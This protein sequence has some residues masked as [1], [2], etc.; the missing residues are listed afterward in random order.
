MSEQRRPPRDSI[1]VGRAVFPLWSKLG[2]AFGLLMA[3][4]LASFGWSDFRHDLQR[5]TDRREV[6]LMGLAQSM[7][8]AIDGDAHAALQRGADM[9]S[10]SFQRLYRWLCSAVEANG[11]MYAVTLTPDDQGRLSYVIDGTPSAPLPLGF[12]IFDVNEGHREALAGE[13]AFVADWQDEWGRYS[14]AFAPIRD[15]QGRVVGLLELDVDAEVEDWLIRVR[16]RQ[17]LNW[18]GLGILLSM[19]L[20]VVFARYLN[21]HLGQLTSSALALAGGDL[22]QRVHIPTRDEIGLLGRAFDSMLQG[23]RERELIRETFGRFVAPEVAARVLANP[24]GARLGG[25]LRTVTI[26]MSDLRG[27]TALTESLEPAVMLGL[28]NRYLSCMA[29]CI[30]AHDGTISEFT[31]DGVLAFFGAPEARPDD[32]RRALACAIDMQIALCG[33]NQREAQ[34]LRM[35]IGVNTGAVVAGN[36]GSSRR[37]KYGVVGDTI[38]QA[39]RLEGAALGGQ[40]LVSQACIQAAG[41]DIL[42]GPGQKLRAKGKKRE[43]GCYPLLAVGE[44]YDLTVP[45]CDSPKVAVDLAALCTRVEG[46]QLVGEPLRARVRG[47]GLHSLVL[48]GGWALEDRQVLQLTLLL[49]DGTSVEELY[50]NVV[51][52]QPG[53][54]GWTAELSLTSVPAQ[55]A[56]KIRALLVA[57]KS[58]PDMDSVR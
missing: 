5:E 42:T 15:G 51:S 52:W 31:G 35:G 7:A 49:E 23:L 34:D 50:A 41:P 13:L 46:K 20:A 33:F 18:I 26:L 57:A 32:A 54:K 44:P 28:L 1:A 58:A 48:E 27:F 8:E 12:P 36:I 45:G 21:R 17:L 3:C 2:L 4:A 39:A 43:V 38:N 56:V 30:M 25:E 24:A 9:E 53:A 6:V 14:S 10:E 55:A 11:L 40:V 47:V 29:D 16:T 37:M 19:T 22:E